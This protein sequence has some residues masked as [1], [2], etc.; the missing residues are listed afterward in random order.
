M[1]LQLNL[2][3]CGLIHILDRKSRDLN[4]NYS[5]VIDLSWPNCF[6]SIC[7]PCFLAS[8][9]TCLRFVKSSEQGLFLMVLLIGS[10]AQ[11]GP[12]LITGLRRICNSNR[13][14]LDYPGRVNWVPATRLN[15]DMNGVVTEPRIWLA[16]PLLWAD[17]QAVNWGW[18]LD[19]R[20]SFQDC[21]LEKHF[22]L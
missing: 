11:S 6:I 5:P 19:A 16:K 4:S 8:Y 3:Q 9:L 7:L 14:E 10:L 18:L 13:N 22:H 1:L 12:N 20:R 17:V 2:K 15:S 21:Q